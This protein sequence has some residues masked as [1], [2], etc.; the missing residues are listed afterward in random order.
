MQAYILRSLG[1][2]GESADLFAATLAELQPNLAYL[3][4]EIGSL[5]GS[6]KVADEARKQ[7]LESE[8]PNGSA[9]TASSELTPVSA[10]S[11]SDS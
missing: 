4:T 6:A 1:R 5:R 3:N 11:M 7:R 8:S 9:R 10:E 2:A